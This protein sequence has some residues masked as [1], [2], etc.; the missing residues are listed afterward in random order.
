MFVTHN[1]ICDKTPSMI[2]MIQRSF[3][4]DAFLIG[5]G[6]DK[7]KAK[8][9]ASSHAFYKKRMEWMLQVLKQKIEKASDKWLAEIAANPDKKTKI[10]LAYEFEQIFASNILHM[11]FG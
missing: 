6:D 3:L 4:N 9:K 7:W 2:T 10:N 1:K 8:R 5:K 11:L